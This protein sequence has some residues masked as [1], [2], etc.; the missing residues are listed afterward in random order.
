MTTKTKEEYKLE[1]KRVFDAAREL[2]D[3]WPEWKQAYARARIEE[4]IEDES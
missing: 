4:I 2:I 1:N 3:S